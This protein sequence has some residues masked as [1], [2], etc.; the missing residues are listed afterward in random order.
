MEERRAHSIFQFVTVLESRRS[1]VVRDPTQ[2][3][4]VF[5]DQDPVLLPGRG[6]LMSC[7][8]PPLASCSSLNPHRSCSVP[9]MALG[10]WYLETY[11]YVNVF[12]SRDYIIH[13]RFPT[14]HGVKT[15]LKQK[16][17]IY[18]LSYD[19]FYKQST[20]I[21]K[22]LHGHKLVFRRGK[23]KTSVSSF[24]KYKSRKHRSSHK[25]LKVLFQ[26]RVPTPLLNTTKQLSED[27][28][29]DDNEG[30]ETLLLAAGS[31]VSTYTTWWCSDCRGSLTTDPCGLSLFTVKCSHHTPE[32]LSDNNNHETDN[33]DNQHSCRFPICCGL[34]QIHI[35]KPVLVLSSGYNKISQT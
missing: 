17:N 16:P 33:N 32:W 7:P 15:L 8:L 11:L 30:T 20:N 18:L 19:F 24:H 4:G 23:R 10:I 12:V 35:L 22:E 21:K 26:S 5:L 28:D 2:K 34:N 31:C 3:S 1:T 6:S 29:F 13:S 9:A 27:W 25:I 14:Q